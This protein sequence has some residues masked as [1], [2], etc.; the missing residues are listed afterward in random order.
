MVQIRNVPDDL[1]AELKVRAAR[2]HQ[3]LTDY[4]LDELTQIVDTPPLDQVLDR[5]SARPRRNLGVRAV[6]LLDEARAE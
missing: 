5:L 3:T 6:D 2:R 1:V 4:L